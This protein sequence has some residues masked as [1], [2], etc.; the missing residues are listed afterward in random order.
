MQDIPCLSTRHLE[1]FLNEGSGDLRVMTHLNS[2]DTCRQLADT[3]RSNNALLD[4]F[5]IL[6]SGPPALGPIRGEELLEDRLPGYALHNEIHRGGQGVVFR[7]TQEGT[8]R[9]VA[10]K[11]L[12][13]GA[14]A[15]SRQRRRFERE[16]EVAAS[17]RH[18]NIVT[19]YGSGRTAAGKNFLAM[20]YIDG[21]P[22]DEYLADIGLAQLRERLEL[23]ARICDAV[24]HA[25]RHG[26]M[27]RD[28]KPSNILV[29]PGGEPRLV[30]FGLA[31]ALGREHSSAVTVSGEFMGTFAYASPE[32]LQGD[33]T[34][35]DTRSDVYALGVILYEMLAGRAPYETTGPMTD[36]I[37]H[38]TTTVP[39]RPSQHHGDV[40][41][42]LD[43]IVLKSLA[44]DAG[45]RY[46]SVDLL[47]DDVRAWLA[48]EPI[49]ARRDSHW[50]VFGKLAKRHRSVITASAAA[51]VGL[52]AATIVSTGMYF[53]ADQAR[54]E[55]EAVTSFLS[56][57]LASMDPANA[58]AHGRE[59]ALREFLDVS[60]T[61][62]D[63]E[64]ADQPLVRAQLHHTIGATY[65]SLTE[66]ETARSHFQSAI[67]LRKQ[68]LGATD[69]STLQSRSEMART[70]EAMHQHTAAEA[71]FTETLATQDDVLGWN[72]PD[73]LRTRA[74]L[75][76]VHWRV[77][78]TTDDA[79]H[80]SRLAAARDLLEEAQQGWRTHAEDPVLLETT[81]LTTYIETMMLLALVHRELD[82]YDEAEDILAKAVIPAL[83]VAP[84]AKFNLPSIKI[85][86]NLALIEK[87][88]AKLEKERGDLE[89]AH[90]HEKEA[91]REL[92]IALVD[93]EFGL[94]EDHLQTVMTI[95]HLGRMYMQMGRD[96]DGEEYLLRGLHLISDRWDECHPELEECLYYVGKMYRQFDRPDMALPFMHRRLE[97]LRKC[98]YANMA[99]HTLAS[100][101]LRIGKTHLSVNEPDAAEALLL[102]AYSL[103]SMHSGAREINEQIVAELTSFYDLD[104]SA[105]VDHIT[106][107]IA[108]LEIT[109]QQ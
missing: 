29:E 43:T 31:K 91:A 45:R 65:L 88:R 52:I 32:Q 4:D 30:D 103:K 15:T 3:I 109:L 2:C 108:E 33:L 18:P 14:L 25:H 101:L 50:Y 79:I 63:A 66:H 94:G 59:V 107:R 40:D 20:E 11:V 35:V 62:I 56:N 34:Q 7:A 57:A 87:A 67:D 83:A 47:R 10:V 24:I 89:K 9:Q 46:A 1:S 76:L 44:K 55:A 104:G 90:E 26:V 92:E 19:I 5:K 49:A 80:S 28:L 41:T 68:Q 106:D 74:G 69:R 72:D 6:Q 100:S 13:Q 48:N 75:A 39:T 21:Q 93:A 70:L 38:I 60:A 58:V 12:L 42:D 98:G 37:R 77:S 22:L 27:H 85:K 99:P 23:F 97:F 86:I 102:E 16:I 84:A 95:I 78:H 81:D 82:D 105:L 36:L 64:F 8:Q 96:D 54:D 71:L 61:Q 53:K 17:L 51:L 73:V